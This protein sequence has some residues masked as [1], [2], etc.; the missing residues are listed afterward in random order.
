LQLESTIDLSSSRW[1]QALELAI[2]SSKEFRGRRETS[3]TFA[4][5]GKGEEL[6]N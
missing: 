2:I 3:G 4:G 1:D 5:E 6:A